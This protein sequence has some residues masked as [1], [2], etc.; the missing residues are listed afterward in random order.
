LVFPP[1]RLPAPL[2]P[3]VIL[4]GNFSYLANS[5]KLIELSAL[6]VTEGLSN[7]VSG[8]SARL[9]GVVLL[10]VI[11]LS[12]FDLA[13]GVP[14]VDIPT[15]QLLKSTLLFKGKMSSIVFLGI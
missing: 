1:L 4:I 2:N 14:L 15:A 11:G 10:L 9:T 3:E 13:I 6:A 8:V 5:S 12:T 7:E